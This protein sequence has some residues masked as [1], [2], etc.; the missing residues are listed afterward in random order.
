MMRKTMAGIADEYAEDMLK[1]A[2]TIGAKQCVILD[3][4]SDSFLRRRPQWLKGTKVFELDRE[5]VLAQKLARTDRENCREGTLLLPY[6]GAVGYGQALRACRQYDPGCSTLLI[7]V[8]RP[9]PLPGAEAT[10]AVNALSGLLGVGSSAVLAVPMGHPLDGGWEEAGLTRLLSAGGFLI[11]ELLTEAQAKDRY[12]LPYART[13]R[14]YCEALP[15]GCG[16]CLAV[17]HR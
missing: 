11:Y 7:A 5:E 14:R 9:L 1:N 4:T 16:L 3:G 17:K 10:E 8:G 2:V 15:A 6:G 12:W 13:F